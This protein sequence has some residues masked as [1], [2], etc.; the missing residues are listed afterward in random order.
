MIIDTAQ[1][2]AVLL[3]KHENGCDMMHGFD[4]SKWMTGTSAERLGLLPAG[5]G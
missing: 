4:W 2:V 5:R 1:A 3:E